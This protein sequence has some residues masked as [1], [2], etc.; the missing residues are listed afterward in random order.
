MRHK[1][2]HRRHNRDGSI[3]TT[4]T[5]RHK[6][7][8]GHTVSDSYSTRYKPKKRKLSDYKGIIIAIIVFYLLAL[9][10]GVMNSIMNAE[11]TG[12][13]FL[14]IAI[15]IPI[16]IA[17]IVKVLRARE[18]RQQQELESASWEC[19]ICHSMNRPDDPVCQCGKPRPKATHTH[20]K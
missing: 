13:L 17:I 9:A 1:S 12:V 19:A 15:T 14:V 6:N 10:N 5:Y 2:I 16:I 11:P 18:E 3:T 4:T 8:F 7:I 20:N